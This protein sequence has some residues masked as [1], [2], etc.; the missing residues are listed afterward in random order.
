MVVNC[1]KLLTENFCGDVEFMVHATK[2]VFTGD[3]VA[4]GMGILYE[5]FWPED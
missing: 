5:C 1:F 3:V 2:L 4:E